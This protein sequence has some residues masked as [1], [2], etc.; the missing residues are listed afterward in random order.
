[1]GD[2]F[3]DGQ[4]GDSFFEEGVTLKNVQDQFDKNAKEITVHINSGGGD[5]REGFAIHDFL[6]NTGKKIITRNIGKCYSI[7]TVVLLAG[8]EREGLGNCEGAIHNPHGSIEGDADKI[9]KYAEWIRKTEE[10]LADFYSEKL[11]IDKEEIKSMMND[12]TFMDAAKMLDKGFITKI[13]EPMKAVALINNNMDISKED[14]SWFEKVIGGME[15]SIKNL[16]KPGEA[17]KNM[18]VKVDD[19][20]E[21][22]IETEDDILQ[23][24]KVFQIKEGERSEEAAAD[25]TY[26]LDDGRKITVVDG[27]IS[28][29]EE[30]VEDS[31][32]V[33]TLKAELEALKAEKAESDAKAEETET[34]LEDQK[35]EIEQVQASLKEMKTKV[36]GKEPI[37]KPIKNQKSI[38][39]DAGLEN[40]GN[41]L[42]KDRG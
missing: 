2:I 3:I 15:T 25:K 8:D 36:F 9:E 30:A 13:V 23:G 17:P 26:T 19:G 14:K 5:V 34:K 22:F 38:E 39:A 42:I 11:G 20:S 4:I 18:V 35:E 29:V 27:V 24:K 16:L 10:D 21:L 31:E 28:A 40:W 37:I 6:R 1:M 12:T 33:E 41:S 32:E 7:A